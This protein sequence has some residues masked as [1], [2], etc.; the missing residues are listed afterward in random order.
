MPSIFEQVLS[1]E[2]LS[3]EEMVV[4]TGGARRKDQLDWLESNHWIY[5]TTRAGMP[6]VGRLY[7]RLK[8]TGINPSKLVGPEP[9]APD[10]G[11]V[12]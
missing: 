2:I 10:M 1:S 4:I 5:H 12:R 11:S 7:A 6:V 3:P 8:L 9:W